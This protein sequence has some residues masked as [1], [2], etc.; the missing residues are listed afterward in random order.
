[1]AKPMPPQGDPES[2][3]CRHCGDPK[4]IVRKFLLCKTCDAPM[5]NGITIRPTWERG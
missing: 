4:V 2:Q 3:I 1:M 5:I